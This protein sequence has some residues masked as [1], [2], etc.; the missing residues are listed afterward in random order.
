LFVIHRHQLRRWSGAAVQRWDGRK[1][2]SLSRAASIEPLHSPVTVF[3]LRPC[4]CGGLAGTK[5][6]ELR[7]EIARGRISVEEAPLALARSRAGR[8][9]EEEKDATE[10]DAVCDAETTCTE[11]CRTKGAQRPRARGERAPAEP[12]PHYCPYRPPRRREHEGR[13]RNGRGATD[14]AARGA[15]EE[16]AVQTK[17]RAGG[18]VKV[19]GTSVRSSGKARRVRE[20]TRALV[21][22][23][24]H[25]KV[26][27]TPVEVLHP[28]TTQRWKKK[29]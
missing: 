13:N 17:S 28:P 22:A 29:C 8:G 12:R 21:A 25:H 14:K 11:R 19:H 7:V 2:R 1:P 4:G 9:R 3:S 16:V 20:V 10:G 26:V 6:A 15:R 27:P 23:R 18:W 24:L 5:C